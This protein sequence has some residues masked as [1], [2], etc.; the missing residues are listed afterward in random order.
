MSRRRR[1]RWWSGAVL[2]VVGLV[3]VAAL[4][5]LAG[6][7][8]EVSQVRI[9]RPQQVGGYDRSCARGRG[10]SFGPAWSD[11]VTVAGGHNGC[12]TRSDMLREQLSEVQLAGRCK[13]RSGVLTDPYT[14]R[15]QRV[16]A[17]QVEIDHVYPLS[18]AW[19]AGAAGWDEQRR[20]DFANDPRNLLVTMA[21]VNRAK[22]D[23]MP[24]QWTPE[25]AAGRC[26]YARQLLTVA[27]A[28]D[29]PVSPADALALT[30]A[31]RQC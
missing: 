2:L 4:T 26:R 24:A 1:R 21:A 14:G 7:W 13:V 17:Q 3:A 23:R 8:Q 29:L 30:L 19:H 11:D 16:T 27:R 28:Y 18:A 25:S 10:C 9:A 31:L 12:D 6:P 20:R 15:V 22:S 5:Q